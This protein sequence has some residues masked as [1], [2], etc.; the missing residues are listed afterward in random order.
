MDSSEVLLCR[1]HV[2]RNAEIQFI[3]VFPRQ[4]QFYFFQRPVSWFTTKLG[5]GRQRS[6]VLPRLKSTTFLKLLT[7]VLTH[8][9]ARK[10]LDELSCHHQPLTGKNRRGSGRCVDYWDCGRWETDMYIARVSQSHYPPPPTHHHHLTLI[11][12]FITVSMLPRCSNANELLFSFSS[13]CD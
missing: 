4:S 9:N 5:S 2:P 1:Q 8:H 10:D 11:F 6:C 7:N 13:L 3:P 12:I